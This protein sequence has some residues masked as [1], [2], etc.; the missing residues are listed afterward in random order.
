VG[1]PEAGP[2][3][4][5]AAVAHAVR[6][7]GR[8]VLH[9]ALTEFLDKLRPHADAPAPPGYGSWLAAAQEVPVLV[10]VDIDAVRKTPWAMEK[11]YLVVNRRYNYQQPTVFTLTARQDLDPRISSRLADWQLSTMVVMESLAQPGPVPVPAAVPRRN[12]RPHRQW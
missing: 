11:L 5:A 1:A 8:P 6:E 2:T 4:L 9:A 7:A 12:L 10:L 3:H